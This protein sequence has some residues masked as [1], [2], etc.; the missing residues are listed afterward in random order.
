[1]KRVVIWFGV[2]LMAGA[3][4]GAA[5]TAW[6]WQRYQS[7]PLPFRESPVRIEVSKG[8]GARSVAIELNRKGVQVE[9]WLFSLAGRWRG[10]ADK[11][12]A[13]VY[14]L[15]APMTVRSLY[16]KLV[17]GEVLLKEVR[18]IEGWTFAQMRAAMAQHG[19]LVQDS[20][21]LSE[22]QLLARIG[23][24]ETQAE[25][26]FFPSTYSFSPG[27]SDLDI[28]R[29]A[30]RQQRKL[31]EDAWA[32][33]APDLPIATPYQA[34]ILA[35]V[36][37][38]ETGR[39]ADRD[40][41]AGVFVNRLRK[42]MLLQSDP[43]TIYGMGA[44]FDGNLRRRDLQADTPYNTYTRAGLPPTP[45]ALPGKAS[46]IAATRPARIDALY[47]VARGDGSS[48]FSNDLSAHNRAVAKFQLGR[49]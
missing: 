33:R 47:F 48:E 49:K 11:M 37:E 32:S 31:L 19:D 40:K 30:Y 6:L 10:D 4:A 28:F 18:F 25:G 24:A 7:A 14:Q 46:L 13:G 16:E 22:S 42:G 20:R 17:K 41:V 26:L 43:T 8:A 5:G 34:L 44:S 3:A 27:S 2:L 39:D 35:S 38:K 21:G 12:K 29:Q 15:E 23:A 45:I 1:M 9:P 36:I